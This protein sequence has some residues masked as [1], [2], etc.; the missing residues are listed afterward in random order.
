L[1]VS[2]SAF[3]GFRF[4]GEEIA[5]AVRWY[6]PIADPVEQAGAEVSL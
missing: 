1:P 2:R 5:V 6:L 3:S 4:P